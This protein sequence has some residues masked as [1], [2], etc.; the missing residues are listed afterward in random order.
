M[1]AEAIRLYEQDSSTFRYFFEE[2]LQPKGNPQAYIINPSTFPQ[3]VDRMCNMITSK[4]GTGPKLP[5]IKNAWLA[6]KAE[7]LDGFA[8][9]AK[10]EL[11]RVLKS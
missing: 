5:D 2:V 11:D 3:V 10:R 7:T 8:W 6:I 4:Y 1:G 9:Q